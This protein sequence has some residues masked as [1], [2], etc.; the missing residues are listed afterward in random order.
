MGKKASRKYDK[1]FISDSINK[2]LKKVPFFSH[3]Y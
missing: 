1:D 2:V 3:V